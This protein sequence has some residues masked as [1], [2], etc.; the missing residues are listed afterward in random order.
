M[1]RPIAFEKLPTARIRAASKLFQTNSFNFLLLYR[2]PPLPPLRTN[3]LFDG[4]RERLSRF[5]K[6][7]RGPWKHQLTLNYWIVEND[8][9]F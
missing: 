3:V 5:G 4:S 7:D 1:A 8:G 2:P 6:V 9:N